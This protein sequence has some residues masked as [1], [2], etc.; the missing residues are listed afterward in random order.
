MKIGHDFTTQEIIELD[1]DTIRRHIYSVGKSGTG[2][3]VLLQNMAINLVS[4]H[5]IA[6]FDPHGSTARTVAD[7]CDPSH[8]VY[9]DATNL[10]YSVGYNPLIGIAKDD[11][12]TAAENILSSF[13]HVWN[14]GPQ[15]PSLL[16]I[17]R[18]VVLL[19]LDSPTPSLLNINRTLTDKTYRTQLLKHC[20]NPAVIA[21]W[22][23][24]FSNMPDRLRE[25]RIASVLNKSGVFVS[26]PYLRNV[27]G[28]SKT[29]DLA[30]LMDNGVSF[31]AN[32]SRGKLGDEPSSLLGSLLTTGFAQAAY[33]REGRDEETL[34]DYTLIV[35][36]FQRFTSGVFAEL[37][38]E[39]RKYRLSLIMAHQ[40]LSQL[41]EELQDAVI[42]TANTTISFRI[43][44]KD[45]RIISE[46]LDVP[47]SDLKDLPNFRARIKTVDG[48]VPGNARL[49]V[50]N[51][52][53]PPGGR[54]G[55]VIEHTRYRHSRPRSEIESEIR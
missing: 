55:A 20:T 37:L 54:L 14:L 6:L 9:F 28:Q 35:D 12:P 19:L 16:Y 24:E 44:A 31:I 45:A 50:T 30:N 10:A 15:T 46:T 40:Y 42:G 51:P 41:S 25:E 32:L 23:G 5:G 1:L 36:E 39:A 47:E 22:T 49:L 11:R 29:L 17:L 53:L 8:T 38:A 43:G 27:L 33:S 52:P 2:K 4:Q 21:Y 3:S 13:A 18:N 34:T 26:N 7:H 48:G